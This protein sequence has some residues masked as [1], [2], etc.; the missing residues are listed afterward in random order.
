MN[1]Y[2]SRAKDSTFWK[3]ISYSRLYQKIRFPERLR[4]NDKEFQFFLNLLGKKNQL[5]FDV[6][7][8]TGEKAAIFKKMAKKVI[9]FEPSPNS[10]R[11]LKKR[12]A[13]SNVTIFPIAIS[14]ISSTCELYVVE[15][16]ETLN[17]I[18]KKQ[19]TEV[20]QY[21]ARD[22]K[23]NTLDIQ[24]DTLD[25]MIKKFGKPEYIKI[26]VE[27]SEREVISGL[28]EPVNFLS[29]ENCTPNFLEEGLSSIDHLLD[30]SGGSALF[31]IY[32]AG[33]FLFKEFIG[34][35]EVKDHL[36]SHNYGA[37]EIFCRKLHVSLKINSN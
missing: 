3:K 34:A 29:F 1:K 6:G 15:N 10:I 8:N 17:S 11:T 36:K 28:S 14:N 30:I 22:S 4:E 5:I 35:N 12:F 37:A 25:N 20:I 19:L 23:I 2:F 13:F 9:C 32:E 18:N 31:N 33:R 16:V 26:D 24:A 21:V 27:G 7:A